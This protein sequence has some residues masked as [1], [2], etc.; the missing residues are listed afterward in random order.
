MYNTS[1]NTQKAIKVNDLSESDLLNQL[2]F[3]LLLLF[4]QSFNLIL[5]PSEQFVDAVKSLLM[6]TL[7]PN[8]KT[9]SCESHVLKKIEHHQN[10]FNKSR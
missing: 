2:Y 3:F 7:Y 1:D 4:V 9:I 6:I 8:G 5:N 10:H